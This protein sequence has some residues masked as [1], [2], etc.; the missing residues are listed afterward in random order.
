MQK[1]EKVN[2]KSIKSQFEKKNEG[3]DFISSKKREKML[4]FFKDQRNEKLQLLKVFK[5][6]SK[7]DCNYHAKNPII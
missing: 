1:R 2:A 3:I 4:N 7:E 6:L 5:V